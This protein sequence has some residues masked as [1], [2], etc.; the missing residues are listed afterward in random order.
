MRNMTIEGT[1]HAWGQVTPQMRESSGE[2]C[3][4]R[5]GHLR[6]AL[7]PGYVEYCKKMR[8]TAPPPRPRRPPVPP[9]H[10]DFK[11]FQDYQ[12]IAYLRLQQH[13]RIGG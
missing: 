1:A 11:S 9:T 10:P 2:R 6:M 3:Q 8:G 4:A 5:S 7:N 13:E 12:R